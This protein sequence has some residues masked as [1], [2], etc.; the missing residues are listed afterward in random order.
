M[1]FLILGCNGMAGHTISRYMLH[2]GHDVLGFDRIISPFV[3]SVAGDATDTDSLR[4]LIESEKFDA[5]INCIG[6]LNP[7]AE[8]RKALAV[9]L[10]SYLLHFLAEATAELDTQV[11]HMST[12]CVFSGKRG[13]YSEQDLLGGTATSKES[14]R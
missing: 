13:G 4:A 11:I 2:Q 8:E 7:F 12:D 6:I 3:K 1:R 10:N 5:G 9:F 14:Y